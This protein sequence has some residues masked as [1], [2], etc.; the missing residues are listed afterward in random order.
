MAKHKP[1]WVD[2]DVM[3]RNQVEKKI[4][5]DCAIYYLIGYESALTEIISMITVAE[6]MS[7]EK[8]IEQIAKK[9]DI[10]N[11]HNLYK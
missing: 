9:M 6:P 2:E 8:L 1:F 4:D 5:P 3:A 7:K 10:V 11:F